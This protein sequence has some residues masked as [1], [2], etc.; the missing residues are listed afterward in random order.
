MKG[1]SNISFKS[2]II[3]RKVEEVNQRR[4]SKTEVEAK[5]ESKLIAQYCHHSIKFPDVM[6]SGG[7][8][9]TKNRSHRCKQNLSL[10]L[11]KKPCCH[12]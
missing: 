10:S 4:K 12:F 7:E 3:T 11:K 8:K 1:K 2:G 6:R 9:T 5:F